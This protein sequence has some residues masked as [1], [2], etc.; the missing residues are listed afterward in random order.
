MKGGTGPWSPLVNLKQDLVLRQHTFLSNQE[1]NSRISRM[2]LCPF[3]LT[4]MDSQD[5][6]PSKRQLAVATTTRVNTVAEAFTRTLGDRRGS[7]PPSSLLLGRRNS[8][9]GTWTCEAS[10]LLLKVRGPFPPLVLGHCPAV[11]PLS[12]ISHLPPFPLVSI[13]RL[14]DAS[15]LA[16]LFLKVSFPFYSIIFRAISL[17]SFQ[18]MSSPALEVSH[19]SDASELIRRQEER[20]QLFRGWLELD[21]VEA[22]SLLKHSLQSLPSCSRIRNEKDGLV[23]LSLFSQSGFSVSLVKY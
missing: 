14:T 23:K 10:V 12:P 1:Q 13:L 17:I 22:S 16:S 9:K 3:T 5:G 4:W 8:P 2:L 11:S 18:D 19:I 15:C 7:Q 6:P 20:V 21:E